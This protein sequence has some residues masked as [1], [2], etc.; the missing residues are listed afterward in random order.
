MRN[1]HSVQAALLG[2]AILH[3]RSK[4]ADS[5]TALSKA[6]GLSPS[7]VGLYIDQLIEDCLVIESGLDQGAKG[8]PKRQ[9]Q[10]TA[11]S[12]WFAGVEFNAARLRAVAIDFAGEV[13]T[14][15]LMPFP[16]SVDRDST[17]QTIDDA[18]ESL[19]K[20][21]KGKL[22]SIGI[23]IPGVVDPIQGIAVHYAFI[24]GWDNVRIVDQFR[25][26]FGTD[27]EIENNLRTIALA[28]RWFGGGLSLDDY[29]IL[30]PRSGFGI[31]IVKEGKLVSGSHHAAGEVGRW[32]WPF[33]GRSG[34]GE[35]H[36]ALSASAIW[37]RLQSDQHSARVPSN[38]YEAFGAMRENAPSL[39]SWP[40][41]VEDFARVMGYL[42]LL[43]DSA[44]YFLHGPLNGLG[45]PFCKA[46][47]ERTGEIMPAI[48]PNIPHI[49]PSTMADDA[50]ALGSASLA[51]EKWI[52]PVRTSVRVEPSES[53]ETA[54]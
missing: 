24:P 23:G 4:R 50:G 40:E 15:L 35:M 53:R 25:K 37:K 36:H 33:H 32:D 16:E 28:E 2:A 29:V 46:I 18:V 3:I 48:K 11:N 27:V 20:K 17:L 21:T 44:V 6:M 19:S 8:R 14:E 43:L 31:A 51:M 54:L 5:R 52:P 22:L 49:V 10:V 47:A 7:T 13:V 9:L 41:V 26:R 12:G 30:G 38:L 1:K 39:P 42:H 45:E 34:P